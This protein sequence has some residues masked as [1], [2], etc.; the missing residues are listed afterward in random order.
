[1]EGVTEKIKTKV[2]ESMESLIEEDINTENLEYLY[3]LVDIHKDLE[4]EKYWK[5]KIMRYRDYGEYSEGNYG[6]RGVPGTGRGRYRDGEYSAGGNYG[7]RGVDSRYRGEEMLD[8]M[9]QGYR[10]YNEGREMYG[11]D[12]KTMESFEY[13]L[14]AFK[15]YYKHL[16]QE[17]SSQEEVQMLEKVAREISNM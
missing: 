5:E 9:Y 1:M 4:N 16:K 3:K 12:N 8:D 11:N 14:K 10:E 7:R 15:D 2:E 6:R 17:A 13:M